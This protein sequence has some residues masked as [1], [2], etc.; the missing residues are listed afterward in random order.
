MDWMLDFFG[1]GLRLLPTGSAVRMSFLQ[2]DPDW[3]WILCLL[4]KRYCLFA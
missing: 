3:I 2:P 1:S 4:K